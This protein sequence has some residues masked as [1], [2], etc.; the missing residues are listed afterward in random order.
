MT[1]SPNY[2]DRLPGIPLDMLVIHYTGMK[3]GEEAKARLCD[4]KFEVS[5]HYLIE[6]DGTVHRLVDEDKRAWH[7][8]VAWWRGGFDVNGHSIG[9]ELVNPGHEFGYKAFPEAQMLALTNLSK[10]ILSRHHICPQNVVGHSDIAPRRKLDPGELFDWQALAKSGIGMWVENTTPTD[11]TDEQAAM[12]L[13]A[14]GYPLADLKATITAFQRHF[15]PSK[16]DGVM[17]SQTGG[18]LKALLDHI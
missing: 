2:N 13:A 18:I 3:S 11:L 12:M 7:A 5:A 6:E 1:V 16:V 15:R 8:G 9:I 10:A 4:P 17:D 14:Y